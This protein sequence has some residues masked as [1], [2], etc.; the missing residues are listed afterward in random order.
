MWDGG[1][2]KAQREQGWFEVIAGNSLLAFR[3]G[4]ESQEP[5][6]SKCFAFMQTDDQ[7]PKRRLFELL[8]S[9]GMQANQQMI[10]LEDKRSEFLEFMSHDLL[11]HC[12]TPQLRTIS[13][14][15]KTHNVGW[16]ARSE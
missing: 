1:Y 14:K 6:S 11:S 3:R 9:Q 15:S 13:P 5:V 12:N 7:K 10:F 8:Q 16:R 4:E 2:V